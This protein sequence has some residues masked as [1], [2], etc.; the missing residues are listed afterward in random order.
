[1]VID[2]ESHLFHGRRMVIDWPAYHSILHACCGTL[3]M[4]K[5]L[6]NIITWIPN[7]PPSLRVVRTGS[8]VG[9]QTKG[10]NV[11]NYKFCLKNLFN[12][13]H[14]LSLVDLINRSVCFSPDNHHLLT[15]CDDNCDSK[16]RVW[17][18]DNNAQPI[19][20]FKIMNAISCRYSSSGAYFA[21][22]Y[23]MHNIINY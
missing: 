6:L 18:L 17:D 23:V 22:G 19:K 1:M 8:S 16:V 15:V 14:R 21:V 2:I 7:H 4:A 9:K 12:T 10:N 11:K 5:K 3:E 13:P 20:S